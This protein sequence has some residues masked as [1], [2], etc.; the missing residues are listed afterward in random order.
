MEIL[1]I[2][3]YAIGLGV[4]LGL[5]L[6]ILFCIVRYLLKDR[7]HSTFSKKPKV[8]TKCK[9]FSKLLVNMIHMNIDPETIELFVKCVNSESSDIYT[10]IVYAVVQE[11]NQLSKEDGEKRV[12]DREI[13]YLSFQTASNETEFNA[14]RNVWEKK[15]NCKYV[16]ILERPIN[17][18]GDEK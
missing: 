11:I 2:I 6:N 1:N 12:L 8:D 10:R 4:I 18:K 16:S 5:L 9:L 17:M 14:Y 7:S 15:H 13:T 3:I